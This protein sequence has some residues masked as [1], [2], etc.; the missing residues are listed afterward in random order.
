MIGHWW[1][2]NLN[3]TLLLPGLIFFLFAKYRGFSD[4]LISMPILKS[5]LWYTTVCDIPFRMTEYSVRKSC[6][7]KLPMTEYSVMAWCAKNTNDVIFRHFILCLPRKYQ[8]RNISSFHYMYDF[9]HSWCFLK[10]KLHWIPQSNQLHSII[11][12]Y[13]VDLF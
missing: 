6:G 9:D 5:G 3:L 7:G 8:W 13:Y 12:K 2:D 1:N 11:Y 4:F 10:I